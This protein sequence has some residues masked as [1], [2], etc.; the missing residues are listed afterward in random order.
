MR[1]IE[2]V[3][4]E[5]TGRLIAAGGL[6]EALTSLLPRGPVARAGLETA[7]LD[8]MARCAGVPLRAML[9]ARGH[10]TRTLETDITIAIGEPAR[11]AELA[12][13]WVGRGFRALKIKVGKDVDAD[14]RAL[15]AIGRAAPQARLRIDANAGYTA[16]QAIAVARACDR[17]GLG[18]AID[19]WE[20]PCAADDREGM[21]E[22]VGGGEGG[23][24]GRRV[25]EGV[26]R[27][28][29]A[30]EEPVR[31]GRQPQ[32]RQARRRPR[33]GADGA[34]G[35]GRGPPDHGRRHGRDAPR[36]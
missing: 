34:R 2:R 31:R 35:A 29:R 26:R 1:E 6:E 17:L 14:V 9:G 21:R 33:R 20:Q 27:L 28:P 11:M 15:E 32:A 8:A 10:A 19:C 18:E 13:E 3:G 7:V 30:R 12:R 4:R 5:L 16:S 22:V 25:G 36:E 24:R 23:R